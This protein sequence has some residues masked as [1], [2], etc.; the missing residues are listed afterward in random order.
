[1]TG[2]FARR[3]AQAMKKTRSWGRPRSVLTL[4]VVAMA[5]CQQPLRDN[6]HVQRI[7]NGLLTAI[8][9]HGQPAAMKLNERM[10]YYR[11]PGVSIAIVNNG[12]IEWAKGYGVL[13]ARGTN[14]VTP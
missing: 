5:G 14:A 4:L 1:M 2:W 11:V 12:K 7:E 9:L 13:D 6:G 3:C 10:T 8:V